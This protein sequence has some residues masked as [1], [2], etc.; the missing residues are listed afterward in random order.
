[1]TE[2]KSRRRTI[3]KLGDEDGAQ[4]AGQLKPTSLWS[5][6]PGLHPDGG[7]LFP[8]MWRQAPITAALVIAS[9]LA[10]HSGLTGIEA[11]A[12]R[13]GEVLLGCAVGLLVTVLMSRIWHVP[14]GMD[15]AR[16]ANPSETAPA[17]VIKAS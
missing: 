4:G 2:T 13:V 6:P 7:D 9:G 1:M 3:G 17:P 5:L 10:Q 12:R 14:P 8:T 11:G 15:P 16:A